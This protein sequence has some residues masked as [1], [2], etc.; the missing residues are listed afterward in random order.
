MAIARMRPPAFAG[1][2][3][4]GRADACARMISDLRPKQPLPASVAGLVPH[5]GWTYSGPTAALTVASIAGTRPET[6]VIF[7]AVHVLDS[8]EASLFDVGRWETPFGSL[9]V[10]E[11][12]ARIVARHPHVRVDPEIHS[13]EHSI[14]VELPLIHSFLGDARILPLMIRPGQ[15]AAEIGRAVAKAALDLGRRVAFLAST[16]LT[17]YGPAFGFEPAGRGEAGVRWAKDVNDRR[18]LEVVERLDPEGVVPEAAANRNACGAG[19]VAATLGALEEYGR[20]RH[21][22]LQHTCSAEVERAYGERP[23]NSVGYASVVFCDTE[24]SPAAV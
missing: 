10:D 23:V 21:V 7:G 2:F 14:E 11:E 24:A 1:R 12:L 20:T 16:D 15:R 19:A 22:E 3:Y 6:V 17:H 9:A 13:E 5:A 4:P 18:F 8:N